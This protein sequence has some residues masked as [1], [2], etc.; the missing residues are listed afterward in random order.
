MSLEMLSSWNHKVQN[1]EDKKER[2]VSI[3]E[4]ANHCKRVCR[5]FQKALCPN[6]LSPWEMQKCMF[7]LVVNSTY[8]IPYWIPEKNQ[9]DPW[10]GFAALAYLWDNPNNTSIEWVVL[11]VWRDCLP[12]LQTDRYLH[13]RNYQ[14]SFLPVT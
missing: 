5:H 1:P 9:L 2:T 11:V 8:S 14:A 6:S 10:E 12:P 7:T 4:V 3:V 13:N